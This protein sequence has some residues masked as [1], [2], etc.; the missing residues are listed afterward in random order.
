MGVSDVL[1]R[2]TAVVA[3]WASLRS[4]GD[5]SIAGYE[6]GGVVL[7]TIAVWLAL[8]LAQRRPLPPA[9]SHFRL[10]LRGQL[11][12]LMHRRR[13]WMCATG[14]STLDSFAAAFLLSLVFKIESLEVCGRGGEQG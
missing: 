13:A 1:S 8:W 6:A 3:V 11:T 12:T 4:Q 5:T 9:F 14:V 2:A 7:L 10:R